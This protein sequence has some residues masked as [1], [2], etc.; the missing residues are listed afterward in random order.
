MD[1]SP[2]R[3]LPPELRNRIAELVLARTEPIDITTTTH[4]KFRDPDLPTPSPC[5]LHRPGYKPAKSHL[6]AI[7]QVCQQLRCENRLL[8]YAVN[9]FNVCIPIHQG[10]L[11]ALA[12][13][14]KHTPQ[15]PKKLREVIGFLESIGAHIIPS[16]SL[17]AMYE[18][19]P[20]T[21]MQCLS[22]QR[23]ALKLMD[24]SVQEIGNRLQGRVMLGLR[25]YCGTV[26]REAVINL[27]DKKGSIREGIR[28]IELASTTH[29]SYCDHYCLYLVGFLKAWEGLLEAAK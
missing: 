5:D 2:L 19:K 26:K 21:G 8:F 12:A 10:L 7:S 11:D 9:T 16:L 27:L 22:T 1:N 4:R 17:T 18:I 28:R 13:N 3:R 15:A 29:E 25:A 14:Q 20:G 6:R 24:A 23:G